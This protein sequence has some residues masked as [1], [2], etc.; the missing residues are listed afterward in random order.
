MTSLEGSHPP[1][2]SNDPVG[3]W[4]GGREL[5]ALNAPPVHWSTCAGGLSSVLGGSLSGSDNA[6]GKKVAFPEQFHELSD[7]ILESGGLEYF[8]KFLKNLG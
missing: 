4:R 8:L 2:R 1:R 5:P 6:L 7:T 3:I